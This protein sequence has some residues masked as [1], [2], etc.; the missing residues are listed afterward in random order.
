M[1]GDTVERALEDVLWFNELGMAVPDG[2]ERM[3]QGRDLAEYQA[4]RAKEERERW[5][6][7]RRLT[8]EDVYGRHSCQRPPDNNDPHRFERWRIEPKGM[9]KT[10]LVGDGKVIRVDYERDQD[11]RGE[12]RRPKNTK[13]YPD[14]MV[15]TAALYWWRVN[16]GSSDSLIAWLEDDCEPTRGY[17]A[18]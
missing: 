2:V 18:Q 12:H 16:D 10:E 15:Y 13:N 1:K 7:E 9:T 17:V 14:G 11:Y 6:W 3:L 8:E 4:Q 5:L